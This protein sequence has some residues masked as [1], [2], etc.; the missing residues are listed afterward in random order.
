MKQ[1]IVWADGQRLL[2]D[3]VHGKIKEIVTAYPKV[4][5]KTVC[6]YLDAWNVPFAMW[7]VAPRRPCGRSG[8]S[9][10]RVRGA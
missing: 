10:A 2:M 6:R 9:I 8:R 1:D 4:K 5:N 3:F 7:M